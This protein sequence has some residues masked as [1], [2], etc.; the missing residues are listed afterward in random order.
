MTPLQ[1]LLLALLNSAAAGSID[2]ELQL[3]GNH[4]IP[5]W[6]PNIFNPLVWAAFPDAHQYYNEHYLSN[7]T[8]DGPGRNYTHP[9]YPKSAVPTVAPPRPRVVSPYNPIV[10]RGSD[11]QNP[12]PNMTPDEDSTESSG[13]LPSGAQ[14]AKRLPFNADAKLAALKNRLPQIVFQAVSGILGSGQILQQVHWLPPGCKCCTPLLAACAGKGLAV[15][16]TSLKLAYCLAEKGITSCKSCAGGA[17]QFQRQHGLSDRPTRRQPRAV[18]PPMPQLSSHAACHAAAA[19]QAIVL[20]CHA[21]SDHDRLPAGTTLRYTG[22]MA[23][24][25]RRLSGPATPTPR[26]APPS[27]LSCRR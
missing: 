27:G 23:Q 6:L 9:R 4:T 21:C 20:R 14:H 24:A 25:L 18:R 26:A 5:G 2:H 15:A 22:C 17:P 7:V 13:A 10:A 8:F 11:Q 12:D 3:F 1:A 19:C 16:V